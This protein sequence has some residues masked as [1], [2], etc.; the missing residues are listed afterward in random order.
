M[1]GAA[2]ASQFTPKSYDE[3]T[4][5]ALEQALIDV[6]QVLKAHDCSVDL[7]V[8]RNLA[9][10]LM[11]FADSGCTDPQELR[12]KALANFDLKQSS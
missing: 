4:L 10:M 8:K 1:E 5:Q 12:S 6:W 3:Q 9:F 7:E 2:M 11:T